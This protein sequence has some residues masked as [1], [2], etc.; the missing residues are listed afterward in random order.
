VPV[1]KR[2]NA[3]WRNVSAR[4]SNTSDSGICLKSSSKSS[5]LKLSSKRNYQMS[6]VKKTWLMYLLMMILLSALMLIVVLLVSDIDWWPL[7]AHF[8]INTNHL[9]TL[10]GHFYCLRIFKIV[11]D[12]IDL[13]YRTNEFAIEMLSSIESIT[14]IWVSMQ[15]SLSILISVTSLVVWK[16]VFDSVI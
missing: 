2:R 11:L 3:S 15:T 4:R 8:V 14:C 1:W 13:R 6:V 12:N 9:E 7:T 10:F 5:D 16:Q